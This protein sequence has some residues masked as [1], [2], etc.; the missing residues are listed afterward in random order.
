MPAV[1]CSG[2]V[3]GAI[4]N[5]PRRSGGRSVRRWVPPAAECALHTVR[6]GVCRTRDERTRGRRDRHTCA[7]PRAL[8]AS[9][10]RVLAGSG[11]VSARR[12]RRTLYHGV[13][14]GGASAARQP[15]LQR[16]V[17]HQ[18]R[19]AAGA[20]ACAAG[21]AVHIC[22]RVARTCSAAAPAALTPHRPPAQSR[23]VG[24][25]RPFNATA[26]ARGGAGM[27]GERGPPVTEEAR[28]RASRAHPGCPAERLRRCLAVA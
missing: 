23:L 1:V 25:L 22:A 13:A 20:C 16:R 27:P 5:Q 8:T 6:T 9:R 7:R 10:P 28:A 21:A 24:Q 4:R 19:R 14:P 3:R 15:L 26:A 2:H 18:R 17:G 12:T 11:C